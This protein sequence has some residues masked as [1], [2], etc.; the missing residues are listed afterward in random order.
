MALVLQELEIGNTWLEEWPFPARPKF[1][2]S[3]SS[4]ILKRELERYARGEIRGRSFLIAGHRGAGKTTLVQRT[5]SDVEREIIERLIKAP[6]GRSI[7]AD[8]RSERPQRPLL[9]KLHGPS[10]LSSKLPNPGEDEP[11]KKSPK[12]NESGTAEQDKPD[13][14]HA[15]LVQITIALYRALAAETARTFT[16]HAREANRRQPRGDQ[17]E[18]AGQ[19]TLELDRA[20]EA[21]LLREFWTRLERREAGVLWPQTVGST[22]K[23]QGIREIVALAT[24]AQAFQ[25]CSGAVK[26]TKTEKDSTSREASVESKSEAN[27]KNLANSFLGVVA[28]GLIGAGA[29]YSQFE[30]APAAAAGLGAALLTTAT[31]NWSSKRALKKERTLDYSFILDRSVQTLDRDLPLVIERI[32]EAGLTPVFAIDELDKVENPNESIGQMIVRLKHLVADYGFFCFLTD[33]DYY[34]YVRNK[35]HIEPYPRE[36]TYFSHSLFVNYQPR[37]LLKFL[38]DILRPEPGTTPAEAEADEL[39]ARVLARFMLHRSRLN[40]VDALREIARHFDENG[41][42]LPQYRGLRGRLAYQFP[43]TLHLAIEFVFDN[44][45]MRERVG[46]DPRFSQI[47]GDMLYALSRAWE[48]DRAGLNGAAAARD[49]QTAGTDEPRFSLERGKLIAYLLQPMLREVP[50]DPD[51]AEEAIQ[52]RLSRS[53]LE[54]LISQLRHLIKI[55]GDLA[56]LRSQLAAVTGIEPI[57]LK[58]LDSIPPASVAPR[59][60]EAVAGHADSFRFLFDVFG[61]EYATI[62]LWEQGNVLPLPIADEIRELSKFILQFDAILRDMDL[63]PSDLVRLEI[64]PASLA[65]TIVEEA[66]VQLDLAAESRLL[67]PELTEHLTVTRSF[68][69]WI[70]ERADGLMVLLRL[71]RYVARS[72]ADLRISLSSVRARELT[73]LA[74]YA[75]IR[76]IADPRLRVNQQAQEAVKQ[77]VSLPADIALPFHPQMA[78]TVAGLTAW[79]TELNDDMPTVR[80]V[81]AI[82]MARF[83][84]LWDGWNPRIVDFILTGTPSAAPVDFDE[85]VVAAKGYWPSALFRRDLQ[86]MTV[87]DWSDLCARAFFGPAESLTPIEILPQPPGPVPAWAFVVALRALGFGLR[88]L[89]AA[90]ERM[91]KKQSSIGDPDLLART[92]EQLTRNA[93]SDVPGALFLMRGQNSLAETA[94]Y[95]PDTPVLALR[96]DA[97]TDYIELIRWL[98]D[99]EA[100]TFQINEGESDAEVVRSQ[101]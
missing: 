21:A 1:M 29:I 99:L 5:V 3:Q 23:D 91:S 81:P 85:I 73:A 35:L 38:I 98:R 14:A 72:P 51:E 16:I 84:R 25:V 19:L 95:R 50:D 71:A 15:A 83:A 49:L 36:H 70:V 33:R 45:I 61:R 63:E 18:L 101:A 11:A 47:A 34:E 2:S 74:R 6:A 22:F 65:S 42:L 10:L 39:D 55:L 67:Y 9:V 69:T 92:M 53:D 28:G 57:E 77:F 89:M 31:L 8:I 79:Q 80:S 66:R 48:N 78:A 27:L 13:A 58:T 100:I 17:L 94:N 56:S 68:V 26:Y 7:S 97:A 20:P 40:V 46:S 54:L 41:R 90:T 30:F 86:N 82:D 87:A 37:D 75:D 93:P 64:L 24:A 59:F 44:S 43:L 76:L 32:R 52:A 12:A 62:E 96:E 60:M 88:T 4:R